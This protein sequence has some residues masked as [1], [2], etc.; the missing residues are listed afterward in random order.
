MSSGK[1]HIVGALVF[2]W[3][4]M[5][6]ISNYFFRPGTLQVFIY[7]VIIILFALWPDVDIN[8]LGQKLFYTVFF[9]ADCIFVYLQEYKI[10]AYFGLLI[11]L[12]VLSKHRGWTHTRLAA[13][14]MPVPLLLIPLYV[15]NEDLLSGLPYYFA[16]VTGYFSHLF[17]DRK[18]I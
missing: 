18:L 5:H 3:L 6:I 14:L 4:F 16:G 7:A 15:Q 11:I 10:A 1:G 9:I 12:P 17:F 8:S 13:V 2:L